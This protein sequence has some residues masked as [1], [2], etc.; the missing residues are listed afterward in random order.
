ME[1][2]EIDLP[3]EALFSLMFEA[4][5]RDITLNQLVNLFL[6]EYVEKNIG[7]EEIKT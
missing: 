4:H 7:T 6:R 2:I 3:N 1:E 5:K